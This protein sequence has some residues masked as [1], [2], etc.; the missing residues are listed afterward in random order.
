MDSIVRKNV[1]GVC[2]GSTGDCCGQ[3]CQRMHVEIVQAVPVIVVNSILS[4]EMYMESVQAVPVTVVD[5]I[6][7]EMYVEI[8]QAVPVAVVHSIQ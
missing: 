6:L 4:V 2:T 1:Y 7:E 5:G 8:V 3:Y